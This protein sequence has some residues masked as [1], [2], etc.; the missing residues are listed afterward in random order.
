[1]Q[2]RAFSTSAEQVTTVFIE[3][4]V[5]LQAFLDLEIGDVYSCIE[6]KPCQWSEFTALKN[7][8]LLRWLFEADWEDRNIP[9]F[10]NEHYILAPGLKRFTLGFQP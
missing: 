2:K 4:D 7:L 1:M 3:K 5:N 10:Q 9:D 8:T 6:K